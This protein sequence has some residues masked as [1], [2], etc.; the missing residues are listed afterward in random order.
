MQPQVPDSAICSVK[1]LQIYLA[2]KRDVKSCVAEEI[3]WGC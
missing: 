3:F 1:F 2:E